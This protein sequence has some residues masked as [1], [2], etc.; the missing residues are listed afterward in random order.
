MLIVIIVLVIV[1][2][3]LLMWLKPFLEYKKIG[4]Y[5]EYKPVSKS[6]DDKYI[7]YCWYQINGFKNINKTGIGYMRRISK[8][9]TKNDLKFLNECIDFLEA[10]L[11]EA[12]EN[13][14]CKFSLPDQIENANIFSI[15]KVI[16]RSRKLLSQYYQGMGCSTCGEAIVMHIWVE[17]RIQQ[18][19]NGEAI[20]SGD[21]DYV[22]NAITE[23]NRK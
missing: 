9:C 10:G 18:I 4:S 14:A 21:L 17:L 23:I 12:G 7:E 19:K 16:K 6:L 22:I 20:K 5:S 2:I 13:D 11:I 15:L 8:A 3:V 1:G